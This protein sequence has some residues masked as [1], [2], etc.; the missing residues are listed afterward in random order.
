MI[1]KKWYVFALISIIVALFCMV[2][3]NYT[4]LSS[5]ITQSIEDVGSSNL[6]QAK[7]ELQAYLE[8]GKSVV[9]TTAVS[10]EYMVD[11]GA[12]AEDIKQFLVYESK[13]YMEEID[14]NFSGIYGLFDGTY[15]DGIGW[16]PDADYDPKTRD[17]YIVASQ[18][19]GEP[20]IVSP[21]LDAQTN[22]IML[23]VCQML[24]DG[25]SVLSLDIKMDRIQEITEKIR[26]NN[27]GYGFVMDK[28]GLVIA[29]SDSKEK[30]KNYL[31]KNSQFI[32]LVNQVQK[33]EKSCFEINLRG[34]TVTVF[35]DTVMDDWS[36]VMIVSNDVLFA[37]A[38]MA[39]LHNIF[40]CG[41][42]S[43]L[44]IA[45]F[46]ITFIRIDQSLEREIESNQKIEEMNRKIIR[47]L[48]RT[49]DAKDHYTNGHSLRVAEY[50]KEIAKRMKKSEKEQELIYYAGLLHDVGKIRVPGSIINKPGK[51]T[52]EE[53]EQIKVHPITSYHILKDIYDDM[54]I[55]V[56]A[57]FHHERFDGAGYP[58]GLKGEDIPEI[59]RIIGVADSYDAM[60]SNR[61]YRKALP[62]HIVR[63]E[64]EKGK[65]VQFD[66]QI[67][68]IMLQLIDEDKSYMLRE[69]ESLQKRVLVVDDEPMNI[70]MVELIM[71]DEPMYE[72]VSAGSGEEALEILAQQ[73]INL[74]L[75]D[76]VMPKMDGFETLSHIKK[77][78]N[79]PVV[80]MTG[81]K[82]LE[83]LE[84][85]AEQGVDDYLTKPFLPLALKE[86]MHG[87]AN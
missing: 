67:A 51:L 8:N 53:Y 18:A 59:A 52:D 72:I 37:D 65:A 40:I 82:H 41:A 14:E 6:A 7:E 16:V 13:R 31:D 48:A 83:T 50:S 42:I 25:E 34:E 1:K 30:G 9:Q 81:D 69:P 5:N 87:I 61:S 73:E 47:A 21:Y 17:W 45:F 57:K 35:S 10:V 38:R 84:K 12:K 70:K 15:I 74:I 80:F 63:S 23:S 46:V 2:M 58:N 60:A 4:A 79:I 66:P 44:I 20:A 71:K 68:E 43:V 27:V 56:G 49:I 86:I 24:K 39:L 19:K 62:R 85:A 55:A 26:L 76:L 32:D 36:V 54:S 3:F 28:S 78:Y 77:K 11:A 22:T 33:K 64:I 29:H 75:L